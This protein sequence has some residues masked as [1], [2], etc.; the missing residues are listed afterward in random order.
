MLLWTT[1]CR[2]FGLFGDVCVLGVCIF[3]VICYINLSATPKN[4]AL[5][6]L[7]SN[8]TDSYG[9]RRRITI[10]S[11]VS[12]SNVKFDEPWRFKTPSIWLGLNNR[13]QDYIPDI[14]GHTISRF[15]QDSGQVTVYDGTK[16]HVGMFYLNYPSTLQ[17]QYNSVVTIRDIRAKAIFYPGRVKSVCYVA[18]IEECLIN[19]FL[20]VVICMSA[21]AFK[22]IVASR[23]VCGPKF[24]PCQ[25]FC[26]PEYQHAG[27]GPFNLYGSDI[28]PG[29]DYAL[30]W[31]LNNAWRCELKCKFGDVKHD[32][33]RPWQQLVA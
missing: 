7:G 30:V 19:N 4:K 1:K 12:Q 6:A 10:G 27:S 5:K 33:S 24:R 21:Q 8:V 16:T 13:L 29:R 2:K 11:F 28:L 14:L 31:Q 25:M 9:G 17:Y 22:S 15:L 23:P 18:F 26:E 3:Y 32:F 20:A